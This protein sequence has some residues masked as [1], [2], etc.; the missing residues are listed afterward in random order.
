MTS[1]PRAMPASLAQRLW[2]HLNGAENAPIA[3]TAIAL[4]LAASSTSLWSPG[5]PLAWATLGLLSGMVLTGVI[6][7]VR[8]SR[9]VVAGLAVLVLSVVLAS[10]LSLV[11][12][13]GRWILALLNAGWLLPFG[14]LYFLRIDRAKVL[15]WVVYPS[16]VHAAVIL[17]HGLTEAGRATGFAYSPNPAAGW[18]TIMGVYCLGTKRYLA[19]SVLIAAIPF[20]QSRL[21][22]LS[23][24]A[25]LVIM[26]IRQPGTRRYLVGILVIGA[27]ALL[28]ANGI[29]RYEPD[30]FWEDLTRR[31]SMERNPHILPTGVVLTGAHNVP[32][33]MALE[34]G[35]PSALVWIGLTGF[36]LWRLRG[37]VRL[38]LLALALLG[39]AD[40]YIWSGPLVP[41]WWL[42]TQ[43]PQDT[44]P[45][46]PPAPGPAVRQPP[47]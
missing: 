21:A 29:D 34:T 32:L 15:G 39:T 4:T 12:G 44:D 30:V 9:P 47:D 38:A 26:L 20:T 18:L 36:A 2:R 19:G 33:R 25:V 3:L 5:A 14:L 17:W 45:P 22:L 11:F 40:Y 13:E 43:V 37:P 6:K 7:V 16:L 23:L 27:I 41:L 10:P 46:P 42:L 35:I 31:W 8:P 24:G 28:T 1:L